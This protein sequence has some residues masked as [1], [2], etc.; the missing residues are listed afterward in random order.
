[1]LKKNIILA[2]SFTFLLCGSVLAL[3]SRHKAA[4][5]YRQE[6][7]VQSRLLLHYCFHLSLDERFVLAGKAGTS[8]FQQTGRLNYGIA[9]G[10]SLYLPR[11]ISLGTGL[12]H[13]EWPDFGI[14]ENSAVLYLSAD[15]AQ[16]ITLAMG[17]GLMSPQLFDNL[18][19]P[20]NFTSE[21][22]TWEL[23]YSL[24]WRVLSVK[25]YSL[26]L[27]IAD[28][29]GL[30]LTD[31]VYPGFL[32]RQEWAFTRKIAVFLDASCHAR[33]FNSGILVIVDSRIEGGV[34]FGL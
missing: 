31:D 14:A 20:F 13:Q 19:S 9:L 4:F 28:Y 7:G 17:L 16:D 33:G 29:H 2:A 23:L 5:Q 21:L 18:A 8:F 11:N 30:E 34:S 12:F 32:C 3:E 26:K 22:R 6:A 25:K 10:Y 15:L 24:G 27:V 1:M